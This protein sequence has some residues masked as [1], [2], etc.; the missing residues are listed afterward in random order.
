MRFLAHMPRS[1]EHLAVCM[2]I[3]DTCLAGRLSS[4]NRVFRM[5]AIFARWR[6]VEKR[7]L[8]TYGQ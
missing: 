7:L 2:S 6:G 4:L 5:A 3:S 8:L 1:F